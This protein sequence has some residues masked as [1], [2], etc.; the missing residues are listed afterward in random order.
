MPKHGKNYRNA[1]EKIE[2]AREYE[3]K[4]AISLIKEIAY[5][6]FDETIELHIRTGLDTRHADQ[7]LRGTIVLPHGLGKGQRV[8]VF[9]EGEAARVA[10]NAG[11]DEVGGDDLVAKVEGGYVDFEIALATKE[12]MGKVGK[13]G[14]VLGPRGLMPNPRTNTVVDAQD[15]PKAIKDSKQGRVE[16]RTDRTNLVHC[17]IGKTSFSEE[18]LGDN[19][20]ALIAA[21]LREKPSG[22]K[23]Q[24][25]KTMTLTSTMGP[26]VP[27]DVAATSGMGAAV[28][29]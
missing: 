10:A 2:T 14:R 16:F 6:K 1:V 8:V 25:L 19:L 29:A 9:A 7:Q 5:A 13:L 11:A 17:P 3:P 28:A 20:A 27:L 12:M 26:G 24:Y 15:L 23:G 18:A 22:S 4:E 21:I